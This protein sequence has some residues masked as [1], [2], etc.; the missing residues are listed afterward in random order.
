MISGSYFNGISLFGVTA[1]IDADATT[2]WFQ[3]TPILT[4]FDFGR[5]RGAPADARARA[6]GKLGACGQRATL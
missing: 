1:L 5:P 4:F 2:V 6:H 3:V